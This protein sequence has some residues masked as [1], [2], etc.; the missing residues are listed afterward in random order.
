M[1]ADKNEVSLFWLSVVENF[2]QE[3]QRRKNDPDLYMSPG[4]AVFVYKNS[5]T[6]LQRL[7]GTYMR[8][9]EDS[10]SLLQ[11]SA[12]RTLAVDARQ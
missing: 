1:S 7:L 9:P 2:E 8:G 10:L 12:K 6:E 11:P 5:I 3:R 4:D